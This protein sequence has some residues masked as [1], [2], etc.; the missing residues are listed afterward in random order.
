MN[1]DKTGGTPSFSRSFTVSDIKNASPELLEAL[2]QIAKSD[3]LSLLN[4]HHYIM[5]I[6]RGTITLLPVQDSKKS[7]SQ[8]I[9]EE[10]RNELYICGAQSVINVLK[11]LMP[12]WGCEIKAAIAAYEKEQGNG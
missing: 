4:G 7:A 10:L 9:D 8:L 11:D 1:T 5:S 12:D 2:H 6:D 3:P